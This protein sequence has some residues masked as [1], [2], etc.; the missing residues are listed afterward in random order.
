MAKPR[1]QRAHSARLETQLTSCLTCS[2]PDSCPSRPCHRH[3][4]A[5]SMPH[6]SA[7]HLDA[8]AEHSTE[9]TAHRAHST[10]HRAQ[11]TAHSAQR[12]EHSA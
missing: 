10:E 12:T 2:P 1:I 4:P 7:A 5:R 8:S 6:L 9:H 11:S 3:I